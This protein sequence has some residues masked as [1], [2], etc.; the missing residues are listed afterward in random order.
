MN[1]DE[2]L[3]SNVLESILKYRQV[4]TEEDMAFVVELA[5]EATEGAYLY[6]L[7]LKEAFLHQKETISRLSS[8]VS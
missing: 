3:Y 4:D 1:I 6:I 7:E 8:N 2:E 5:K